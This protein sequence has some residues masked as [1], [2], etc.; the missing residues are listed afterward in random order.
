MNYNKADFIASYGIIAASCPK[1]T[2]R[3]SA[4]QAVPTWVSPASSTSCATARTLPVCP[5]HRKQTAT[6]NFCEVGQ[7]LFC[8]SAR[9]WLCKVSNADRERWDDLINNYFE[10]PRHHTLLVQ[11]ID[12]RHAPSADDLQMLE[13]SA[14]PSD[15]LCCGIDQSR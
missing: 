6:I 1:V 8:G 10:A 12:S 9:L 14:L 15:P 4:S 11:L 5:V 13:V 7:L 2:V 3:N